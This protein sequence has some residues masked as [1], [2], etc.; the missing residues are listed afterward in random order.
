MSRLDWSRP[1]TPDNVAI[2][3]REDPAKMQ[4]DARA[5]GWSSIAQKRRRAERG[6]AC[7]S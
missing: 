5:A 6:S 4:G 3:T 7:R 2:I 1:W